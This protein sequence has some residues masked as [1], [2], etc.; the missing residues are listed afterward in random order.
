MHII[1]QV[2]KKMILVF[3]KRTFPWLP[4]VNVV[5]G[6]I[7]NNIPIIKSITIKKE[8]TGEGAGK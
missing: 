4:S 6:N 8:R 2:I 3:S 1:V 5:T 7:R